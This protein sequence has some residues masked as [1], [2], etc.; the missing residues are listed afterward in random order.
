MNCKNCNNLLEPQARFCPRCGITIEGNTGVS[1]VD[2]SIQA[3]PSESRPIEAEATLITPKESLSLAANPQMLV[4]HSQHA[5]AAEQTQ[6]PQWGSN[7][8][9]GG[10]TPYTPL[11]YPVQDQPSPFT[12]SPQME[13]MEQT[14]PPQWGN[15][16]QPEGP[17]PYTPLSYPVQ[18]QPS[19]FTQPAPFAQYGPHQAPTV[20]QSLAV[21]MDVQQQ[22]GQRARRPRRGGCLLRLVLVLALL[23]AVFVG[24]WFVA[25]RPYVHGI[26]ESELNNAMTAAVNQLPPNAG[27]S[28]LLLHP[29]KQ[30]QVPENALEELI[31]LNIAPASPVQNPVVHVNTQAVRLEFT[32]HQNLLSLDFSFPC[33]VSLVPALDEQ[34]NLVARNVSIEGI[35]SLVMSSDE[36]T[37]LLNQKL[38]QAVKKLNHPIASVRLQQGEIDIAL[39]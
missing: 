3:I 16:L 29:N 27:Q 1:G 9:P 19:P 25:L 30:F 10:P 32:L 23:L 33:A 13:R 6:P 2:H 34:G 36:M 15:Y 18:D 24:A 21:G 20:S 8:Q 14:Q 4:Q 12:Q 17:T 22:K 38:G 26:A 35:A 5:Q 11:S 39:R 7:F 37:S 31:K 28:L